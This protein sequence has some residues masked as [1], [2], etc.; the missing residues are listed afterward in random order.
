MTSSVILRQ[1]GTQ[2]PKD[3]IQ[4]QI[5]Q[6]FHL[7]LDEELTHHHGNL[8]NAATPRTR[9]GYFFRLPI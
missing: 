5:L 2:F 8:G 3:E 6:H 7:D 9:T 1:L 4:N